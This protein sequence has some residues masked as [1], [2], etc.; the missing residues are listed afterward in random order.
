MVWCLLPF[1]IMLA[2]SAS[3]Q[4]QE[5]WVSWALSMTLQL[6]LPGAKGPWAA[7]IEALVLPPTIWLFAPLLAC[8]LPWSTQEIVHG[9]CPHFLLAA[10]LAFS[11]LAP[12]R[13]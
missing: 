7:F 2:V 13:T 8:K 4:V 6:M 3:S 11:L 10:S 12:R 5:T 9:L 1:Y